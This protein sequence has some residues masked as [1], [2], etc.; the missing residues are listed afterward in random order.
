MYS[1][2]TAKSISARKEN[3]R[4]LGLF[5]LR[6]IVSKS[7]QRIHITKIKREGEYAKSIS[8]FMQN[9]PIDINKS[10]YLGEFSTKIK[11]TFILDRIK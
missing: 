10:L 6:E 9:T 2:N 7:K 3:I 4:D 1:E 5:L 8:P 11:K